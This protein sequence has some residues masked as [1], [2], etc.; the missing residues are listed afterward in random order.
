[1]R[2]YSFNDLFETM[3][4][5]ME[6]MFEND[7]G[8]F[9]QALFP[10]TTPLI[11]GKNELTTTDG[12]YFRRPVTELAET[13]SEYIANIELP[14]VDKKDIKINIEDKSVEIKVE[15]NDEKTEKDKDGNVIG[16]ARQYAGFYKCF[17]LPE[18]VKPEDISAEY[19]NG[20]LK[21]AIPKKEL[22]TKK[23]VKQIE[24]K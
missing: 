8:L 3:R 7:F 18:N 17:S 23:E 5:E 4:R 16:Y 2:T 21:L 9:N 10:G 19:K 1:M 6:Q 11:S 20:V 15:K 13:D 24:V 22:E 14:G 12:K